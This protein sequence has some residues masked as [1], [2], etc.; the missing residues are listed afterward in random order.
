MNSLK[1][2]NRRLT[3]RRLASVSVIALLAAISM[4][5]AQAQSVYSPGGLFIHP[6]AFT[7]PSHQFSAYAAAFTQDEASG[8]SQAYFPLALTYVPIDKL[9]VSALAVYHEGKNTAPYGHFGAFVKYQL[10]SDT[11]SHPAFALT[12]A[13]VAH[14]ELESSIAGVFSRAFAR[15]DRVFATLHLGVKWGRS[16]DG[17]GGKSDLGGFVGAQIPLSR[18]WNLVGETSSRLKF[19][20]ASASSVGFMYQ[21]RKGLG[22]SLG[23]VNSGRSSRMNPFFGVGIPVGN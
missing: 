2:K 22:I 7:P 10:L 6:T 1:A 5:S 19:D 9:Q 11:P 3:L 20:R 15:Q 8:R 14:D 17:N 21:T 16:S 12:G 4:I 13:Y 18:E 23:M